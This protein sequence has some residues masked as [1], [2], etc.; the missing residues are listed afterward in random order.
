M[1]SPNVNALRN[2]MNRARER[3]ANAEQHSMRVQRNSANRVAAAHESYRQTLER[4][5]ARGERP[6]LGSRVITARAEQNA[7][8]Q[9]QTA[10]NS[11]RSAITNFTNAEKAYKNAKKAENNARSLAA[12]LARLSR[13]RH[14]SPP[15]RASPLRRSNK[16]EAAARRQAQANRKAARLAELRAERAATESAAAQLSQ[17]E[18][19]YERIFRSNSRNVQ[20]KFLNY[21]QQ[22][23]GI[24]AQNFY[25]PNGTLYRPAIIKSKVSP[26]K[27]TNV[28]SKA[29]RAVLFKQ[30]NTFA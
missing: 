4:M 7:R 27:T 28:N 29:K 30:V 17:L 2:A 22:W 19:Q 20:S 23:L 18:E 26:N 21:A 5:R 8:R 6:R 9:I 25:K 12:E 1:S 24:P 14:T 16:N 11:V 13:S 3:W 10:Y 15:R